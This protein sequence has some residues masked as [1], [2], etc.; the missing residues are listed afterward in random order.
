MLAVD[1]LISLTGDE[2]VSRT[3]IRPDSIFLD[4]QGLVEE[5]VLF[6]MTA[7]T[8]AALAVKTAEPLASAT[9]AG[10]LAA[11]KKM[12]FHGRPHAGTPIEVTARV[13][14]RVDDFSVV[15]GAAFQ[16]GHLLA[17]GQLTVFVPRADGP[18]ADGR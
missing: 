3:V 15:S 16:G 9:E 7:Q 8:F 14:S 11:V 18:R 4:G 12:S 6:E 10:F 17:E 2:A 13:I 1:E 5:A